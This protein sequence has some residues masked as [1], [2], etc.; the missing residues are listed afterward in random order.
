ML[1]WH[2]DTYTAGRWI[3]G[4]GE[5]DQ[6]MTLPMFKSCAFVA[7]WGRG[8]GRSVQYMRTQRG[9][10]YVFDSDV[11]VEDLRTRSH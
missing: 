8:P 5:C 1:Q 4:A 6:G 10:G 2:K 7:S 11:K 3:D 9:A